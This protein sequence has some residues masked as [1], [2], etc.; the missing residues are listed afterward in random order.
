MRITFSLFLSYSYILASVQCE[1]RSHNDK[2]FLAI[3][4][5]PGSIGPKWF[6]L[7]PRYNLGSGHT[8]MS[9][10]SVTTCFTI[11]SMNKIIAYKQLILVFLLHFSV[12]L[13][14]NITGITTTTAMA[15]AGR[16]GPLAPHMRPCALH[17]C[18]EWMWDNPPSVFLGGW[19]CVWPS[20]ALLFQQWCI[21]TKLEFF[22]GHTHHQPRQKLHLLAWEVVTYS[23]KASARSARPHVGR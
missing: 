17:R 19:G 7:R 10:T 20:K 22:E 8:A 23:F 5:M 4:N 3:P 18:F 9:V 14:K 12:A 6:G 11:Y 2:S 16:N 15:A 1:N 13:A 21:S